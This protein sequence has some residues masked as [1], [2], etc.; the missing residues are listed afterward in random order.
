MG[1]CLSV[2]HSHHH[3]GQYVTDDDEE[4]FCTPECISSQGE[5]HNPS[6]RY[7]FE[8]PTP[9]RIS[10]DVGDLGALGSLFYKRGSW[11]RSRDNNNNHNNN[12][13]NN[14]NNNNTAVGHV[15]NYISTL[16][17]FLGGV[18]ARNRVHHVNQLCTGDYSFASYLASPLLK[19]FDVHA[20]EAV[21]KSYAESAAKAAARDA[22]VFLEE[23]DIAMVST[24]NSTYHEPERVCNVFTPSSA[25]REDYR[26][27][28]HDDLAKS[29]GDSDWEELKKP[30]KASNLW[31]RHHEEGINETFNIFTNSKWEEPKPI[32]QVENLREEHNQHEEAIAEITDKFTTSQWEEPKKPNKVE[33]LWVQQNEQEE[34]TMAETPIAETT[35]DKFT[36]SQW[37]EPKKK[38]KKTENVWVKQNQHIEEA[39]DK[40]IDKFNNKSSSNFTFWVSNNEEPETNEKGTNE[41]WVSVLNSIQARAKA[42]RRQRRKSSLA[43]AHGGGTPE[44]VQRCGSNGKVYGGAGLDR[45][46]RC[47]SGGKAYFGGGGGLGGFQRCNSIGKSPGAGAPELVQILQRWGSIGRAHG[48][49]APEIIQRLQ[50]WG[51]KGHSGVTPERYHRYGS[52]SKAYGAGG[53]AWERVQRCG[54]RKKTVRFSSD[55][56]C[57]PNSPA[58]LLVPH[59]PRPLDDAPTLEDFSAIGREVWEKVKHSPSLT[60][61]E[62]KKLCELSSEILR[63][64]DMLNRASKV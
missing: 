41:K 4:G 62:Y 43:K 7:S 29:V 13:N 24:S 8:F 25:G 39:I 50:R 38:P 12:H 54:S 32:R 14:N 53:G 49:G 17:M 52:L 63:E 37:E 57:P 58:E 9:P 56:R 18:N 16:D 22:F 34:S 44:R 64:A 21:A 23:N 6:G 55:T 28:H 30:R 20:M 31:V 47:G 19:G 11:S 10:A 61:F 36:T 42:R 60:K 45:V 27:V 35:T 5:S 48:A 2:G 51:S 46:Q 1:V 59:P 26:D 15:P 3:H 33:N 40:T